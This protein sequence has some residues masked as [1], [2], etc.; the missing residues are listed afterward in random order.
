MTYECKGCEKRYVGCH[1]E[2]EAYKAYKEYL[3]E[4]QAKELAGRMTIYWTPQR[5]KAYKKKQAYLRGK[6]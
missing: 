4:M 2:C 5:I 6:R 3:A 1:S